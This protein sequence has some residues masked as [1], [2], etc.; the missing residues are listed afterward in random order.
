[1]DFAY[2][3][4]YGDVWND[5]D[6]LVYRDPNFTYPTTHGIVD[7]IQWEGWREG[8]DDTRFLATLISKA[9]NSTS[10]RLIVANALATGEALA[11][12]RKRIIAQI[13]LYP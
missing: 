8:V 4:A 9:G 1:M 3:F 12:M 11:S 2:Q 13:L 5:Y 10:A 6:D 7:T